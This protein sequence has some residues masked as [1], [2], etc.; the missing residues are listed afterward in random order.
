VIKSTNP[1]F[2]T[3]TDGWVSGRELWGVAIYMDSLELMTRLSGLVDVL[4]AVYDE[5]KGL[6][7]LIVVRKSPFL[8]ES[9]EGMQGNRLESF[10]PAVQPLFIDLLASPSAL[11]DLQSC[12]EYGGC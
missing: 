9:E 11:P 5:E 12:C 1:E 6:M 2:A 10:K 3:D 7:H 8:F 4:E